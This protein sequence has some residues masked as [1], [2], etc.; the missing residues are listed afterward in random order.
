MIAG[1]LVPHGKAVRVDEGWMLSGHWPFAHG[2]HHATRLPTAAWLHY[3]NG[4]I[5]DKS[6]AP[7]WRA[8]HLPASDCVILDTWYTSGLRGTGSTD[9]AMDGVFAN[10]NHNRR[11][12]LPE[13]SVLSDRRYA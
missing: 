3:E 5:A 6:G 2:C 13:E 1:T 11:Y 8:F 4:P 7:Q 10:D 9:Y 12:S